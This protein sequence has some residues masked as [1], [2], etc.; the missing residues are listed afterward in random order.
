MDRLADAIRGRPAEEAPLQAVQE[1][2]VS[3]VRHVR[4]SPVSAP[5]WMFAD[6]AQQYEIL[7]RSAP[8]PLIRFEDAIVVFGAR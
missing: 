2:M 8:R 7:R 6:T 5:L 3:L 4:E 1:A